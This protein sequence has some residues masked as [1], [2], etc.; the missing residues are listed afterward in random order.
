M[1]D[2]YKKYKDIGIL[3]IVTSKG[4]SFKMKAMFNIND[5]DKLSRCKQYFNDMGMIIYHI[6]LRLITRMLIKRYS[7]LILLEDLMFQKN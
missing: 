6:H 2:K 3:Y 1:L 5:K 4:I 7:H